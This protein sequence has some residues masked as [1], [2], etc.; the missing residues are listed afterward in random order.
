MT[1]SIADQIKCVERELA[2]RRNVYPK[3]VQRG[4]LTQAKADHELEAM[5]AVLDTL[6]RVKE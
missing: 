3:W 4:K 5:A 2:L 6:R 1:V